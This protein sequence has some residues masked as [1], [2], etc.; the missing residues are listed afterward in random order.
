MRS[1][2]GLQV[3]D[4]GGQP[5]ALGDLLRGASGSG[6]GPRQART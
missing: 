5:Q 6:I 4:L 3:V 2:R 1:I